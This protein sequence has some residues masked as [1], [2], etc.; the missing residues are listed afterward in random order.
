[1]IVER[2]NDMVSNNQRK[3]ISLIIIVCLVALALMTMGGL[4]FH[5]HHDCLEHH[6]EQ[7][8]DICLQFDKILDQLKNMSLVVLVIVAG[9]LLLQL[10]GKNNFAQS[11]LLQY[12]TPVTLKVKM[13]H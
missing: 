13:T 2:P 1:M 9:Q 8:C 6:S 10:L 11:I 4:I 12:P 3:S 7:G 5:R